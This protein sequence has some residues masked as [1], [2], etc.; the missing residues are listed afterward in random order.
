ME[1]C[2]GRDVCGRMLQFGVAI[3]C[4]SSQVHSTNESDNSLSSFVSHLLRSTKNI[5]GRFLSIALPTFPLAAVLPT[6]CK[7]LAG[8]LGVK[9]SRPR[10]PLGLAWIQERRLQKKRTVWESSVH[11]NKIRMFWALPWCR[12]G[13]QFGSTQRHSVPQTAPGAPWKG[14]SPKGVPTGHPGAVLQ[15]RKVSLRSSHQGILITALMRSETFFFLFVPQMQ[16]ASVLGIRQWAEPVARQWLLKQ[17]LPNP[18]FLTPK[19]WRLFSE[20]NQDGEEDMV[21]I[22]M[23]L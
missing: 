13:L 20:W 21:K 22:K 18:L 19:Q 17:A 2:G 23:E 14:P 3:F 15:G 16:I 6:W 7:E 8:S 4:T 10:Q 11:M 9:G 1:E 5:Q 12:L